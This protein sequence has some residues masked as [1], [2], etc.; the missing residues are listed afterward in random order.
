M[1]IG[2]G[3][4]YGLMDQKG[5]LEFCA[6]EGELLTITKEVDP[7]Y[8][9]AAITKGLE[10]GPALV[11]EQIKGY[12]KWRVVTNLFSRRERMANYFGATR[13]T[14]SKRVLEALQ[15]PIP[16]KLV[17][18]APCQE[19]VIVQGIDVLKTLPVIK[20]TQLD[21]GPVISGGVAMITV[22]KEMGG[23]DRSFNLSFH[24]IN[25]GLGKDWISLA[26]LYSRHFLEVLYYHKSKKEEYPITINLGLSPALNIVSSGGAFPQIRPIGA[27]DLEMAGNLQ[28]QAVEFCKAKT[29]DAYALAQAEIVLEGKVLYDEKITEAP[30]AKS[31]ERSKG[32]ER[33]YFFPEFL[34]YEGLADRAFKV[35]IT[36]ITFKNRPDYYTPLA[37]SVEGFNMSAVI[38]EA[39]IY[40]ACRNTAPNIFMNCHIPDAMRGVLGAV[41][42]CRVVH[43][44]QQGISQNLIN[45]AFGAVKDLKWVIA[46]DEDVD[47]YD[48]SDLLWAMTVRTRADEDINITK[49][50]GVGLFATKWS[51][52]TT[53]PIS[54]KYRALRPKFESVDLTK[55][56]S[57]EDL[58][59]GLALMSDGGR[60]LAKRRV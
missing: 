45:A 27:D 49:G 30:P 1:W 34:G 22:P 36:A 39:S 5:V 51:V 42:Q 26:T 55:W 2:G 6:R 3:M 38:T 35:Q 4:N 23:G 60:S 56:L 11:F 46:V 17:T 44:M 53:V 15:N 33:T 16:P 37:D 58:S 18:Q 47:I 25:P 57:P 48:P 41:I 24:R 28:G 13:E 54:D 20:Q 40:H 14:L 8:E 21:I 19:N 9:I 7:T 32:A 59:K 43:E 29:V 31:A 12:P 50:A 52:D 10:G